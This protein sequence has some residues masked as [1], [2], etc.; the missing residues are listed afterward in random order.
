MSLHAIDPLN[1]G[2]PI[3]AAG[4]SEGEEFVHSVDDAPQA[5]PSFDNNQVIGQLNSGN[6]WGA[7]TITFSFLQSVP[8]WDVD[9]EGPGFVAFTNEQMS[10]TRNV[11]S[12]WD[13]LI[14]PTITE[15]VDNEYSNITFANSNYNV[16]YAHAYQPGSY[17]N[18]G[19]VWLNAP[20]YTELY[21]PD[22]GDY[23]FMTIL[24]EVGHALGLNHPGA[25]NGGSPTYANDAEYAQDTHQWTVMSYFSAG[26]TGADWNGGSGWQYAQTP[27]VHDVL[28]L[29]TIYGADTTTRTGNTVYGFNSNAGSNIFDFSLNQSPVLTIYDA[30]GIDTLDLSGFTLRAIIDLTPGAYSSAGGSSSTMT[31]NI[32]IADNTIIEYAYGGSGNDTIRG[33]SADNLLSGGG[34]DDYLFGLEGNDVLEGGSGTDWVE[35][36]YSFA[37]YGFSFL[38]T[39]ISI[40]GEGTDVVAN[41][42]EWFQFADMSISYSGLSSYFTEVEIEAVGDHKLISSANQYYIEDTHGNQTALTMNG[43]PVL[44]TTFAGYSAVHVESNG[45]GGFEILWSYAGGY[46]YWQVNGSGEFQSYGLIDAVNAYDHE[47][48]LSFDINQDG[49]IGHTL[50]TI[51]STGGDKLLSSNADRY[52]IEDESGARVGIS[53]NGQGIG[54]STFPGYAA[55]HAESNGSGGYGVLWQHA[56]GYSNWDVDATGAFQKYSDVDTSNVF[57]YEEIFQFDI[58]NDGQTGHILTTL[59]T[60][61]SVDLL[62][63]SA[64]QYFVED[65]GVDRVGLTMNGQ[66]VGSDTFAGYEAIHAE[67]DGA[68]GYDILWKHTAGHSF[69]NVDASGEFQAFA[70]VDAS[71]IFGHEE[72]FQFDINNDGEIGAHWTTIEASGD[73]KLLSL[74]G[75]QYFV[76]DGG[77]NRIGLTMN[78]Q[79]VG[80]NTFAGFQAEHVE[81]NG[82]GGFV[83]LWSFPG[84][85]SYWQVGAGGEFESFGMVTASNTNEFEEIFQID[86]DGNGIVEPSNSLSQLVSAYEADE[87]IQQNLGETGEPD[88]PLEAHDFLV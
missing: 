31:Y 58:N 26:Y 59:E 69:W 54:A 77:G 83:V 15:Q 42:V 30:G 2:C 23:Y 66:A 63:N 48:V 1:C 50:S 20:T 36:T 34:G 40:T 53:L 14:A 9:R 29:Q 5:A 76:E 45:A 32:G 72:T 46:S 62:S 70:F 11:L 52:F 35:Y 8:W 73:S 78:G 67:S 84:G 49:R 4:A 13:D 6:S 75:E 56:G 85:N 60:T 44:L 57:N 19:E 39:S 25:Y 43:Q 79:A 27:M 37:S 51:E 18:S 82:E 12:L 3:C 87:V 33:N 74:G 7:G 16:S 68:G 86:L 47:E 55:I 65:A 21:N 38:L 22:P 80:P 61:G 81:S 64:G 10:A 24:H 17:L 41:D 88:G 71:N 28:A